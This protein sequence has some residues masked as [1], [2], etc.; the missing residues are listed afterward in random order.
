MHFGEQDEPTFIHRSQSE[1]ERD[2]ALRGK[3][4]A[5][6]DHYRLF[7][8]LSA[9]AV[10]PRAEDFAALNE[11]LA[12]SHDSVEELLLAWAEDRSTAGVSRVEMIFDRLQTVR[13]LSDDAFLSLWSF[14]A[15]RFDG[16]LAQTVPDTWGNPRLW[17][18]AERIAR[19]GFIPVALEQRGRAIVAAFETGAALGWLADLYRGQL[20]AHGRIPPRASPEKRVISAEELD[21]VTPIILE[22]LERTGVLGLLQL[23]D[24][25]S[26]LLAWIQ[27][28]PK[29]GSASAQQA[30]A[31]LTAKDAGFLAILDHL[32]TQVRTAGNDG[33]TVTNSYFRRDYVDLFMDFDGV[34]ARL[35][36][37]AE[38]PPGTMQADARA[39]LDEI[40]GG[41]EW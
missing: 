8:A 9:P 36:G 20:F 10:A 13:P 33:Q 32:R 17:T 38:G 31:S 11:A 6:P 23:P 29:E 1:F 14:F 19:Q 15:D 2:I 16:P 28:G 40:E 24:G 12:T 27:G 41:G 5:S 37:L 25:V 21:L 39:K 3:R 4:L 30:I 7:F 22:R 34:I 18:L 35:K 26:A